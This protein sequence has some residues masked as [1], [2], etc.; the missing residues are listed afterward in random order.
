MLNEE[1]M[2]KIIFSLGIMLILVFFSSFVEAETFIYAVEP[3][4]QGAYLINLGGLSIMESRQFH[5]LFYE[6]S[7]A[8]ARDRVY[9]VVSPQEIHSSG[10]PVEIYL[11]KADAAL[12]DAPLNPKTGLAFSALTEDE[13]GALGFRAVAGLIQP[14]EGIA[15]QNQDE[16]LLPSSSDGS[17]GDSQ[18]LQEPEKTNWAL[19]LLPAALF[20]ILVFYIFW[21]RRKPEPSSGA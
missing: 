19:F 13:V 12:Q 10:I 7:I 18:V 17:P 1:K 16:G 6:K 3:S 8:Y 11:L 20:L 15:V 4:T 21:M 2:K 5:A 14:I 9:F